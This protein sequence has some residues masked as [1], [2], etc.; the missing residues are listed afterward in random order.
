[1]D[2]FFEDPTGRNNKWAK[3]MIFGVILALVVTFLVLM[4]TKDEIKVDE[5]TGA[6]MI[7]AIIVIMLGSVFLQGFKANRGTRRCGG[8]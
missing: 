6:I 4:L 8:C 1:M 2:E 7:V 3:L 5:T